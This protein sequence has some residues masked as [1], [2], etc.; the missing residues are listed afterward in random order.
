MADIFLS[1]AKKDREFA[2]R[3]TDALEALGWSVWWDREIPAGQT[4]RDVLE[5]ALANMRCMVVLWSK[6]SIK[7]EW[8]KEEA[9]EGH[10]QGKLVPVLI[11]DVR[12]PMGF[13]AI[14]AADLIGWN[15]SKE[16]AGFKQLVA[17]LQSALGK[18]ANPET[19][20]VETKSAVA[21][22]LRHE[23]GDAIWQTTRQSGTATKTMRLHQWLEKLPWWTYAATTVLVT[24]IIAS[25]MLSQRA[26]TSIKG[27]SVSLPVNPLDAGELR[28]TRIEVPT[29]AA[30]QQA[31]PAEKSPTMPIFNPSEM[32]IEKKPAKRIETSRTKSIPIPSGPANSYRCAEVLARAQLG[33][34]LS[35]ADR[36][37]L[38]KE[39]Q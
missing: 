10:T 26:A 3:I 5:N 21:Q 35:D 22:T 7:S 14:Q 9:E 8:V 37:A 2:R 30:P 39:C 32:P 27:P 31:R 19:A 13:R 25:M 15:D 28:P 16:F 1:Y 6:N 36:D 12:P 23:S 18:P 11:E 33:E 4:W 17:A 34:P 29:I 38:K 20:V 24:M